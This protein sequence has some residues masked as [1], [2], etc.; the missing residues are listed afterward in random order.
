M[1][2]ARDVRAGRVEL[3]VEAACEP[4]RIPHRDPSARSIWGV[5]GG[6]GER[7]ALDSDGAEPASLVEAEVLDI[8]HGRADG[9]RGGVLRGKDRDGVLDEPAPDAAA[10]AVAPDREAR[11]LD[12]VVP[13]CGHDLQV[14]DHGSDVVDRHEHTAEIDRGVEPLGGVL[15]EREQRPQLVSAARGAI[16]R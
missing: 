10:P 5:P 9:D 6:G 2:N 4:D 11:D 13:G 12:H 15:R 7:V 3:A 16:P 14:S 8:R 1:A